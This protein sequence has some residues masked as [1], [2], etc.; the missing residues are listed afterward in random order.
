MDKNSV[1]ILGINGHIGQHAA[2][3]FVKAGWKVK[4]FGRSDKAKIAGVNFVAGDANS[5]DDMKRAIG[6]SAVVLNGLNLPY[7]QWGDGQLEALNSRVIAA[8][9]SPGRTLMFPG[10]VYNYQASDRVIAPETPVNPETERGAIRVRTEALYEK[11]AAGDDLQVIILR[12]GDFYAP[13]MVGDWYDQAIMRDAAKGKVA[14]P[15]AANIKH[16]WAYLPDF[17]EA[18]VQVAA[19]REML[20][21]FENFHF[22]GHFESHADLMAAI[23]KAA[24][25]PLKTVS[26]PWFILKLMS[27]FSG[28]MRGVLEMRYLWNHPMELVDP[29]LDALLGPDFGT[30]FEDAVAATAAPFFEKA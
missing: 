20:S 9:K 11:A 18:F 3:A 28:V 17:G 29:R 4:G 27:L 19:R 10:N 24:P 22:A 23:K 14:M 5:V 15:A 13:N 25:K 2:R 16:A 12:A 7:D 8:A 30:P 26:F 1:T 6:D 21:D